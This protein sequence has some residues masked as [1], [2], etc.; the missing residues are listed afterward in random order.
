MSVT[1][2]MALMIAVAVTIGV[3]VKAPTRYCLLI[4]AKS[5]KKSAAIADMPPLSPSMLSSMLNELT[6]PTIQTTL[7]A[8][9]MATLASAACDAATPGFRRRATAP[10]APRERPA[11]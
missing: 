9:P 4:N 5:R 2:L 7:R 3:Q 11:A 8:P 1:A 10:A 6:S